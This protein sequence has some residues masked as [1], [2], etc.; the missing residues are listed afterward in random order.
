MCHEQTDFNCLKM[1]A[2]LYNPMQEI[3]MMGVAME[4]REK[5]ICWRYL[6]V[7]PEPT[8]YAKA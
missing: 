5:L 7:D 1:L 6:R 2:I 4:A 3:E 8:H